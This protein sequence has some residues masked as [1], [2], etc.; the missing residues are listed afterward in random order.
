MIYLIE[1]DKK[2]LLYA[3]DTGLFPESTW[4]YLAAHPVKLNLVS[5][6]ATHA[7]QASESGHMGFAADAKIRD[8]LMKEGLADETT[9]FVANHFTHN[10]GVT[11]DEM[12]PAAE[13]YGFLVSYD[14]MEVEI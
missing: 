13:K 5:L 2:A 3:H 6:D 4:E 11:Y 14:G 10:A 7:V 12:L 9:V 1:K 8:R